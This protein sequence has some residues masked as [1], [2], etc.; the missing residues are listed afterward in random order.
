MTRPRL[1]GLRW[2]VLTLLAVF[3]M[4]PL[5]VMVTSSVKPLADVQ[6]DFTWW[7]SHVDAA[8]VRRHVA[9][10]CRWRGYFVNSLVV[11]RGRDGLSVLIAIFAA[12]AVSRYRFRGRGV[13]TDTVLSTQ[14]FPGILF[15]LPLFLIF[16]NI[17]TRPA[18]SS[19]R[20]AG[21]A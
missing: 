14:M 13:F 16:V 5:Y 8:A 3:T 19:V 15:L 12:Y 4:L 7:P 20:H 2:V 21:W 9:A 6:G 11:S 18:F 17:D 10:P 1:R